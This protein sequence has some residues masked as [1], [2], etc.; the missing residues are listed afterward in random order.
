M[1]LQRSDGF[2]K[3]MDEVFPLTELDGFPLND[4]LKVT[5]KIL[6]ILVQK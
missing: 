6:D 1:L 4:A 2:I 5:E 3:N